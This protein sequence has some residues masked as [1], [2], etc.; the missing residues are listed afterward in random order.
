MIPHVLKQNIGYYSFKNISEP[1]D[2]VIDLR[3]DRQRDQDMNN[4]ASKTLNFGLKVIK[5][6]PELISHEKS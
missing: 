2:M 5:E 1:E 4:K 6:K 3:T